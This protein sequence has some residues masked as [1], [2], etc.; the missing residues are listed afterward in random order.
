MDSKVSSPSRGQQAAKAS[1]SSPRLEELGAIEEIALGG[2]GSMAG[3]M[4]GGPNRMK[5][6]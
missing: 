6:P 4:P 5:H 2:F 1:Y 3:N